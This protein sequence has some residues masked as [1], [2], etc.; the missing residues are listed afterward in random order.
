MYHSRF[1][2]SHYQSGYHWGYQLKNHGVFISDQRTFVITEKRKAFALKCLPIYQ[3]YFPEILDEIKGIA[4]GQEM[5][6][7]DLCT[8]LLS[9]YCFEFSNH[10]TCFACYDDEHLIFGRN[11]DFL[12][13]LEKLYM[14]CLYDLDG[15]Y[16]FNGNT[17]AFV[18]ME[19]GV[20]EYGLAVGLT[21]VYPYQN[22][23]GLNGGMLVRYILEK[24]KNTKEAITFL[25]QVPIAS[26]F[27]LTIADAMKNIVTVE[28][29]PE[30]LAVI[31]PSDN[32]HFVVASNTFHHLNMKPFEKKNIDD[33][34]SEERYR[35]ACQALKKQCHYSLQYA[36]DILSGKYGF[37]CQYDRK[38]G[39]DTVWSVIYD[40]KDRKI[41]R[42]EGNPSR[43]K[44]KE[45]KR[46]RFVKSEI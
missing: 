9:M 36:I 39:G 4:D 2:K 45:D 10:C 29:Y 32:E 17:T 34:N 46:F 24:C 7:E 31:L 44:Y 43:K 19:D 40:L 21:F 11:S 28:C 18:E 20:N 26:C 15:F 41:W 27:V 23:Y 8:F 38:N 37:M 16:A 14:N 33:W 5:S 13:E 1:K 42:V 12:I 25:Q 6:Y 30:H 3:Q 22:G 35:T